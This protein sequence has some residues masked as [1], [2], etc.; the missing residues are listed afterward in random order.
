VSVASSA[1]RR[2][3]PLLLTAALALTPACAAVQG[4]TK[5]GMTPILVNGIEGFLTEPDPVVAEGAIVANMKLIEGVVATYPD[6][7]LLLNM[8]AMARANY[9]FG[10]VQDQLEA[11]R[12]A[13][14]DQ[15]TAAQ[16]LQD[17]VVMSYK[18]GRAYAERAL[19]EDGG[20]AD[21]IA[22][23]SL[24]EVPLEDLQAA[25]AGLDADAAPSVFWLAF[26]WGGAMQTNLDP[27]E[28]TQLPK[29]ELLT[30]TALALDEHVFY[31]VGPHMLAGVFFGFRA[32]ALGGD[33]EKAL[34]H[35]EKAK[36]QGG[37]LLPDVLKAQFVYAQTEQAEPFEATLKAV[38]EARPRP[39]RALLDTLAQIKACRLL[40]NIDAYFLT[41]AQ[42][43]PE[44]CQRLPHRYRLRA[45]PLD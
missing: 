2:G 32:P 20:F 22:G 16:V 36:A 26:N 43:V 28:A 39:D 33:P 30:N 34:A 5:A 9:A 41:D 12:L 18:A 24:E 31:D 37:V 8:A 42:P 21:A 23:R 10:F 27:A 19:M 35:F 7:V 14:P 44:R 11:L 29:V 1:A 4:A 15:Q 25:L 45:E 6:D 17:R 13:H 40:A 38:I 3:R